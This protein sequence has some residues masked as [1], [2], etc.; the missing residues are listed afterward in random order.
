MVKS[1]ITS[2]LLDIDGTLL[3]SVEAHAK[4]FHEAAS[5]LGFTE[6]PYEEIYDAIGMGGDRLIPLICAQPEDSKVGQELKRTKKKI[7]DEKY[8]HK[9][10][11]YPNADK[12]VRKMKDKGFK[13]AIAT[14]AGKE[15]METMLKPHH[16][17]DC[18]D[19]FTTSSDDVN[20]KPSGDIPYLAAKKLG[21]VPHESIMIGDTP[22]DVIAARKA[23]IR[24]IA[25][26]CT[27]WTME[28]MIERDAAPD[29]MWSDASDLLKNWDDSLLGRAQG[30]L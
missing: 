25:F 7:F 5:R 2:V 30:S 6:M 13:I 3:D 14:S 20:S 18:I 10:K 22:Y 12:L 16:I 28:R 9:L 8:L 23:G 11:L 24:V 26:S 19:A 1:T 4:A 21:S 27:G 17:L 15:E 29:E